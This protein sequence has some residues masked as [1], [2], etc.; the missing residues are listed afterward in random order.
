MAELTLISAPAGF[1]KTTLVSEWLAGW[2]GSPNRSPGCRWTPGTATPPAFWLTSLRP[3]RPSSAGIGAGVMAALESPQ[4][5]PTEALLTALLNEIATV[6]QEF[7][8]VLDDYHLVD[9][10]PVDA[11]C[12]SPFCSSISRRRC[13]W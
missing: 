10:K 8:L 2:A 11:L 5:P 9:A 1:G 4:P 3:C 13:A 12:R 7:I 6:R